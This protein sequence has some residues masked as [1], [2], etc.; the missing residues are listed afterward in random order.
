MHKINWYFG[1]SLLL[2]AFFSGAI[3]GLHFYREDFLGGYASFRRRILRLGHIAL[4]ALGIINV[5]YSLGP[6]V[7]VR[8][9]NDMVAG[10]GFVI[11][12]ATMPAVCF[13]S[14]WRAGFR[15]LFF[16][17]VAALAVA[18]IRTLQTGAP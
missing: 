8:S 3:I 7:T 5:L 9:P 18:V 14:S 4:A 12:G 1:W 13:L 17:P 6:V 2:T 10:L 11:G 16:I 15:Y